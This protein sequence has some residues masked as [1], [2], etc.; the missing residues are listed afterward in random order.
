MNRKPNFS[1]CFIENKDGK[2]QIHQ[3][4]SLLFVLSGRVKVTIQDNMYTLGKEDVLAVN[5]NYRYRWT[6]QESGILLLVY[7]DYFHLL[8]FTGNRLPFFFCNST[9]DTGDKYIRLRGILNEL[10]SEY[11]VNVKHPTLLECSCFYRI[12]HELIRF[13][14]SGN[15]I[16]AQTGALEQGSEAMLQYIYANYNRHISLQEMADYMYMLPTSFSRF[17]R[18]KTGMTFTKYLNDLRFLMAMDDVVH[19]DKTIANIAVDHGFPSASA[20]S[21]GFCKIYGMPPFLYRKKYASGEKIEHMEQNSVEWE[22]ADASM[23]MPIPDMS[24]FHKIGFS[25]VNIEVDVSL[26]KPH[27]NIWTKA[28]CLGA[29]HELLSAALQCQVI[30]AKKALGIVYGRVDGIFYPQMELRPEHGM[31]IVNYQCLDSVFDFLVENRIHPFIYMENKYETILKSPFRYV[32]RKNSEIIFNT[33]DECLSVLDDFV[34]HMLQRYGQEEVEQWIFEVWYNEQ[35][36]NTLGMSGSFFEHFTHIYQTIRKHLKHA[37]IGGCGF[38]GGGDHTQKFSYWIK[39]WQ[40]QPVCPDFISVALVPY[41]PGTVQT[42]GK[43]QRSL[44]KSYYMEHFSLTENLLKELGWGDIPLYTTEWNLT[45]SQRN[46]FNDSCGK[47]A[48]MLRQMCHLTNHLPFAAYMGLSDLTAVFY[49]SGQIFFGGGGLITRTGLTKPAFWALRFMHLMDDWVIDCCENYL[50][51][52]DRN[53]KYSILIFNVKEPKYDYYLNEEDAVKPGNMSDLFSDAAS[54]EISIQLNHMEDGMYQIYEY[55]VSPE[56][57]SAFEACQRL[58]NAGRISLD[59]ME[60]LK[61]ICIPYQKNGQQ[62]AE[63]GHMEIKEILLA[64]EIRLLTILK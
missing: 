30:K 61:S 2:E 60:Y 56:A 32:K 41:L 58:G 47:A 33:I 36:E 42:K 9:M 46:Y 17:F 19:S 38:G 63:G 28:I 37:F 24:V 64:Q 16:D 59:N 15:G 14:M 23:K 4:I 21:A 49:D 53:N 18:R 34:V 13:F 26:Y 54:L 25:H 39:E 8:G 52:T 48:L 10:V 45:I 6:W 44:L 12:A 40:K 35:D 3:N 7:L 22:G 1:L 57:G 29:A 20:F 27:D 62:K 43:F 50:I 55:G 31:H 51:T 11:A 5:S